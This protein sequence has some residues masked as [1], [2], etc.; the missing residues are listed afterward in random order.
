MLERALMQQC[1]IKGE[2]HFEA[3]FG[4]RP[5]SLPDEVGSFVFLRLVEHAEQVA[6]EAGPTEWVG[7]DPL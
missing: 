3:L 2:Y 4:K 5:R 7:S 6:V 1:G